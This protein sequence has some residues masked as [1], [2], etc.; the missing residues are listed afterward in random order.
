MAEVPLS[1]SRGDSLGSGPFRLGHSPME[2]IAFMLAAG[3]RK[4][5]EGGKKKKGIQA[6]SVL[7]NIS[8]VR[9]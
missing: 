3:K 7:P 4:H 5:V 9:L 8:N 1:C 2:S 6:R